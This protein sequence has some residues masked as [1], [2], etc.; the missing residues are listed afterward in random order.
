MPNENAETILKTWLSSF[1][2]DRTGAVLL[3]IESGAFTYSVLR[4]WGC[5]LHYPVGIIC[6]SLEI[7]DEVANKMGIFQNKV[8]NSNMPPSELLDAL[9]TYKDDLIVIQFSAGRYTADNFETIKTVC[10]RGECQNDELSAPM[11]VLFEHVI[12]ETYQEYF[13]M[14]VELEESD[15]NHLSRSM[16]ACL[17]EV[18]KQKILCCSQVMEYEI[19]KTRKEK[20]AS[21]GRDSNFWIAVISM[22]AFSFFDQSADSSEKVIQ[23]LSETLCRAYALADSYEFYD[24]IPDLFREEFNKAIPGIC[25]FFPE[26]K[27]SGLSA[28]NLEVV[29]YDSDF[30]YIPQAL[31]IR[32]CEQLRP[33][34]TTNQVKEA[35]AKANILCIQGQ[36]RVYR[37]VKKRIGNTTLR[38][39]CLKRETLEENSQEMSF[40]D[41]FRIRGG[42][43]E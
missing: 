21:Y 24:Q 6:E 29:F 11:V 40:L 33:I 23:Y 19:M 34:C 15:L 9:E 26:K 17:T 18:L 4:K 14:V 28:Q 39:V 37:T 8:L 35:L 16:V 7:S 12:P 27:A 36:A 42:K 10:M 25:K 2:G 13:S 20:A 3:L 30:Y 43:Y 5:R 38:V 41:M 31:F 22:I 32:I 1:S